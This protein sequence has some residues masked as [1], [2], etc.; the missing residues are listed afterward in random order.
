MEL[1][2]G[3]ERLRLSFFLSGSSMAFEKS[4]TLF[5]VD[6][7]LFSAIFFGPFSRKT[8]KIRGLFKMKIAIAC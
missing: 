1:L 2:T 6:L 3:A 7:V 4:G 5:V 8:G